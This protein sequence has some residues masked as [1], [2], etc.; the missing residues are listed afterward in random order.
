VHPL[1]LPVPKTKMLLMLLRKQKWTREVC[2]GILFVTG[3]KVRK[4]LALAGRMLGQHVAI[5]K[6]TE[7]RVRDLLLKGRVIIERRALEWLVRRRGV[8]KLKGEKK[9]D[10]AEFEKLLKI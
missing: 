8:D 1:F 6:V 10:L 3:N 5:K 2:G 4:N 7:V 9:D